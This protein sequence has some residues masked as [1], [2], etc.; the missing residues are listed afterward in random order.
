MFIR[1]RLIG[2]R[3][4]DFRLEPL[5]TKTFTIGIFMHIV[6]VLTHSNLQNTDLTAKP[7]PV[8]IKNCPFLPRPRLSSVPSAD[9]K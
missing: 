6:N 7:T 5:F 4:A 2:K 1:Y 8:S 3:Q 9:H